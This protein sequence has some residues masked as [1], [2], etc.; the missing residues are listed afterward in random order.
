M[1]RAWT[2]LSV[3]VDNHTYIKRSLGVLIASL[4]L[5]WITAMS[6]IRGGPNGK[7]SF[8]FGS[9]IF[10]LGFLLKIFDWFED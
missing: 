6:K 3:F 1:A 2:R 7:L 10:L 8:A 5:E 4:L 9:K